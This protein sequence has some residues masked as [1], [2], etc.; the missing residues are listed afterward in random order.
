LKPR[1]LLVTAKELA[2]GT[3]KPRQSNLNRA[4]STAYYAMFHTLARCAADCLVGGSAA[5]RSDKAW[6]Q[7][8]RAIDHGVVK[9]TCENNKAIL[10]KFPGPIQDFAALFITMQQKRH[11][12]DYD[13]LHKSKKSEVNV[14]IA[15]VEAAISGFAACDIKDRR[16][17]SAFVIFKLRK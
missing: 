8:Y 12:A 1:D 3:Q 14:D 16:A 15:R 10:A 2:S 6:Q 9:A 13:P 7:A 11:A 4:T 17:F 5:N